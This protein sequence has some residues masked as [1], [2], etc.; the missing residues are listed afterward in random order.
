MD[1]LLQELA[2][3]NYMTILFDD[4]DNYVNDGIEYLNDNK[5]SNSNSITSIIEDI[6]KVIENFSESEKGNIIN[7]LRTILI[8]FSE[9]LK[10]KDKYIDLINTYKEDHHDMILPN[11]ISI[12]E[13]ILL[14][15]LV[16]ILINVQEYKNELE[17]YN[18]LSNKSVNR[19]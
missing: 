16:N 14:N 2:N 17:E 3:T 7:K 9:M 4:L 15:E 6:Y 11:N 5:L 10:N 18:S 19:L 12:L 1:I 13:L 8:G